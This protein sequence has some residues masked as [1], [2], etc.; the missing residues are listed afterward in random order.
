MLEDEENDGHDREEVDE[1]DDYI[2]GPR[3]PGTPQTKVERYLRMRARGRTLF[4]SNWYQNMRLFFELSDEA[5][6][7]GQQE[8]V[9]A[10]L[11]DV[12]ENASVC[13]YDNRRAIV[14]RFIRL[15]EKTYISKAD[16]LSVFQIIDRDED[17]EHLLPE[18]FRVR[19]IYKLIGQ[20]PTP[21]LDIK[22]YPY[23][24]PGLLQMLPYERDATYASHCK[25][26]WPLFAITL[27]YA[28]VGRQ[29]AALEIFQRLVQ[30]NH[31]ATSAVHRSDLRSDDFVTIVLSAMTRSC[32]AW[33]WRRRAFALVLRAL[34]L[35]A[36]PLAPPL[37]AH[38]MWVLRALLDAAADR[39]DLRLAANALVMLF[40]RAAPHL[41]D[42]DTVQLFY[43]HARRLDE[44][45]L[46]E[47]LFN[48]ALRAY[49]L[50]DGPPAPD[51]DAD[52]D[53]DPD[54]RPPGPRPPLGAGLVRF[55]EFLVLE[56]RNVHLARRLAQQVAAAE[57]DVPAPL[58]GRLVALAAEYGFAGDAR[59]L[60]E[61]WTAAPAPERDFVAGSPG[62]MLKMVSLYANLIRRAVEDNRGVHMGA[63]V[64]RRRRS[65][66]IGRHR[67]LEV[68]EGEAELG[69]GEEGEGKVVE[70][71][72][73]EAEEADAGE[74]APADG[75]SEADVTAEDLDAQS[76]SSAKAF[77]WLRPRDPPE[78]GELEQKAIEGV[79]KAM[80]ELALPEEWDEGWEV[81]DTKVDEHLLDLRAF[82][83]RV[84]N[85][86]K[87]RHASLT[88][89]DHFALGALARAHF[90][91]G[92]VRMGFEVFL[93]ISKIGA[94]YDMYDVN[95]ALSALASRSPHTAAR[96]MKRMQD[97]GLKLNAV[98][99]GTVIHQA[100][101][102][103]DM[104][105]VKQLFRRA[106]DSGIKQLSFKTLGTLLRAAISTQTDAAVSLDSAEE[107]LDL[108]LDRNSVPTT[109]MG[110]DCV[111]AA[112]QAD[113]PIMAYRFW[114][115]MLKGKVEW[116]DEMQTRTR[117][118]IARR[119]KDHTRLGFLDP[120]RARVMLGQLRED[121]ASVTRRRYQRA[122]P[123]KPGG[124][125]I[126]AR[127]R[128]GGHGRAR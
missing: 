50:E 29:R 109:N 84:L 11:E 75:A 61:R 49:E 70:G 35:S 105:L 98:S 23:F 82:A 93:V 10:L 113:H 17:L 78:P 80:E 28:T 14:E 21:D 4:P 19:G 22:I 121:D 62:T 60:W 38:V 31:L 63:T 36:P 124:A 73:T 127:A 88:E 79:W 32:L 99:Y 56:R 83:E 9:P 30:T 96:L 8:L 57:I 55:L 15:Y 34:Q 24:V 111:V 43:E 128:R 47:E 44:L 45:P 116:D 104:A 74:E 91:L 118:L 48:A 65:R 54:A 3:I 59:R 13:S 39:D 126:V 71:E 27:D 123:L 64:N 26:L 114:K 94:K 117:A 46:L 101:L 86:F 53:A 7:N 52:A 37:V 125:R 89:L 18:S 119:I 77:N 107:V 5:L 95:I 103:E 115:M 16:V 69:A 41:V 110:R 108:L 25:T 100:I 90:M 102:H 1:N 122:Q 2:L 106:Y 12:K 85:E 97:S 51:A 6:D 42:E 120:D 66:F 68:D 112:L 72:S 40:D 67:K 58:R 92:K 76:V 87:Y 33:N 20:Y 81:F